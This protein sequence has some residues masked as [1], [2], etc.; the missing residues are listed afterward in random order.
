MSNRETITVDGIEY[1]RADSV[2]RPLTDGRV[3][4]RGDRSGVFYGTLESRTGTEVKLTDCRRIWYW[5]GAASIS[6]LALTGPK[7]PDECK[8]PDAVAEHEILD[9]IE[10]IPCTEAAAAIINDVPPWRA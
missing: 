1:V 2:G 4:V 8:F 10:V 9:A 5:A 6:E 3:I 7:R